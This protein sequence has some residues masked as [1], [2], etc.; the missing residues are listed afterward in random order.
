MNTDT[1]DF[2]R[3]VEVKFISISEFLRLTVGAHME[4]KHVQGEKV[5]PLRAA[6]EE[7]WSLA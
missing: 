4:V 5:V 2:L 3:N 1:Q 6:P 7:S